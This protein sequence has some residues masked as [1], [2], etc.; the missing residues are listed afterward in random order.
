MCAK[1]TVCSRQHLLRASVSSWLQSPRRAGLGHPR[2]SM[3]VDCRL[4]CAGHAPAGVL[5]N[6]S[7]ASSGYSVTTPCGAVDSASCGQA[8]SPMLQGCRPLG[9]LAASGGNSTLVEITP[10]GLSLGACLVGRARGTCARV[11]IGRARDL[12]CTRDE[13]YA[14]GAEP[15]GR[16]RAVASLLFCGRVCPRVGVLLAR[17]S[18][19]CP[20]QC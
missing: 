15:G 12:V 11:R 16:T 6:G 20:A 5:P 3:C 19:C 10:Q 17:V 9:A 14:H 4:P 7:A 13:H 1:G 2:R 18:V 8:A